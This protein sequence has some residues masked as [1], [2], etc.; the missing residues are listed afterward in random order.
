LATYGISSIAIHPVSAHEAFLVATKDYHMW[1]AYV[2]YD[3]ADWHYSHAAKIIW[4]SRDITKSCAHFSDAEP[5]SDSSPTTFVITV[6]LS[7]H[8]AAYSMA[9]NV[10]SG[11]CSQPRLMLGGGVDDA[12]CRLTCSGLSRINGRVWAV[13]QRAIEGSD[14]IPYA[15]HVALCSTTNG[16]DWREEGFVGSHPCWGK[17]LYVTAEEY[18]YVAGNAVVYRA[19]ATNKLGY[20]SASLKYVIAEADSWRMMVP[21]VGQATSIESSLINVDTIA[22]PMGTLWGAFN[23]NEA[24]W[25]E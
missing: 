23:W 3:D 20:D 8:G 25:G 5:L 15:Y 14:G 21:G 4:R 19:L 13:T 6:D 12:G 22:V 17:L 11:V 1:I 16:K 10:T 7:N 2:Y 18:C 24:D 9:Y